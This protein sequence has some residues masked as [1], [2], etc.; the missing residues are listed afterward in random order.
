MEARSEDLR[1]SAYQLDT[2]TDEL[3]PYKVLSDLSVL[4]S[5]RKEVVQTAT[6]LT[7]NEMFTCWAE[8]ARVRV[9]GPSS[10][11]TMEEPG[12][13]IVGLALRR[14][15]S[16]L[17]IATAQRLM[18]KDLD[19]EGQLVLSVGKP[20][21]SFRLVVWHPTHTR[22]LG[23]AFERELTTWEI[24][25]Q[26]EQVNPRRY[27]VIVQSAAIL[28]FS[29]SGEVPQVVT[30]T[31]E[32]GLMRTVDMDSETVLF[33][34]RP[35]AM[36][37]LYSNIL[38]ACHFPLGSLLSLGKSNNE[39]SLWNWEKKEKLHTL[40]IKSNDMK[41]CAYLQGRI[42]LAD[43][44]ARTLTIL[45]TCELSGKL[46]F[47]A[48]IDYSLDIPLISQIAVRVT[49]LGDVEV[50]CL[51]KDS[52]DT[53]PIP[54]LKASP[55]LLIEEEQKREE[56]GKRRT[57]PSKSESRKKPP[58]SPSLPS[59][60]V[61][62]LQRKIEELQTKLD[63]G[64]V[65]S[66]VK[67]RVDK[68]IS[69]NMEKLSGI[70]REE[71]QK[72]QVSMKI[73]LAQS[74]KEQFQST[75]LPNFE[76]S[77]KEL[78]TQVTSTFQEGVKEY[79]ER[80]QLEDIKFQTVI[81]HMKT[82]VEASTDLTGK[83]GKAAFK[84]LKRVNELEVRLT[85]RVTTAPVAREEPM[86][87]F[88]VEKQVSALKLE[89]DR[90]LRN[91]EFEAAIGLAMTEREERAIYSVLNVINPAALYQAKPLSNGLSLRLCHRLL[92]HFPARAELPECVLWLQE[93]CKSIVVKG[94][95]PSLVQNILEMMVSRSKSSPEISPA[96]ETFF[97][98]IMQDMHDRHR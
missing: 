16:F 45:S 19:R 88:P 68:V 5:F 22:T 87:A 26:K 23:T 18:V 10:S 84:Q 79:S 92:T 61:L 72:I 73:L 44:K 31:L 25:E 63:S 47:S 37:A 15:C 53:F 43:T 82:A 50:M 85:E 95:D 42:F 2:T 51:G 36:S 34:T 90:L 49:S 75:I 9:V 6:L 86:H 4:R 64:A 38:Y 66:G 3:P 14:D 80:N 24:S 62:S 48:I 17:A 96:K 33:E 1:S 21:P 65:V 81:Q 40:T 27:K 94:E 89:L 93:I 60:Q 57:K 46:R 56:E 98:K 71:Q 67:E 8:E 39:L 12:Q 70:I 28:N 97:S 41:L 30:M 52:I 69:D 74:F 7:C 11:L 76:G 54:D 32:G 78:F 91:E 59:D 20:D 29:F 58:S 13:K 83:L 77:I 35:H 55:E